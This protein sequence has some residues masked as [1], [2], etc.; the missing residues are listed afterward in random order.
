MADYYPLI[1]RAIEGLTD[2]SPAVRKAVYERAR[3]ALISQ[4]KTL[5]PPVSVSDLE[6]ERV[7]LDQAIVAVEALYVQ[8]T[9]QEAE[10]HIPQEPAQQLLEPISEVV[11]QPEIPVQPDVVPEEAEPVD[12]NVALSQEELEPEAEAITP[13]EV[14]V[15]R[16]RIGSKHRSSGQANRIRAII[17]VASILAVIVS[18]AGWK[19]YNHERQQAREEAAA[20]DQPTET[21]DNSAPADTGK[22][23]ERLGGEVIPPNNLGTGSQGTSA[24]QNQQP[25]V[26]VQ[27][28]ILFETDPQTAQLPMSQ[29][30]II[31]SAGITQW[32]LEDRDGGDGRPME[33]VA[34][35]DVSFPQTGLKLQLTLRKN[36]EG[37]AFSHVI[38]LT[39]SQP[40]DKTDYQVLNAAMVQ[41]K[42]N[43][44]E[45]RGIL[46]SG[47]VLPVTNNV[48]VVGL[49]DIPAD[50]E[51]N[52][53][54]LQEKNWV[55]VNVVFPNGR[56]GLISIEKGPTGF[57]IINEAFRRW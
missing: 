52:Q 57:Q 37:G 19:L 4:L 24:A 18:I 51:R 3:N 32:R 9:P 43:K 44:E 49:S 21:A 38:E 35:A 16:P 11:S 8:P 10:T 53:Q 23:T 40:D 20:V 6:R 26:A 48:F 5:E 41:L 39:F 13:P 30:K 28:A 33:T 14:V 1:A 56:R 31:A 45:P 55:D 17:L 54:L 36:T 25:A 46:L 47:M 7:A 34:I 27:E 2:K 50:I 42:D 29:Q 15:E 12:E 22:F